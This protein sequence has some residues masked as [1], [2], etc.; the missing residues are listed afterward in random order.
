MSTIRSVRP[1]AFVLSL[2][3]AGASFAYQPDAAHEKAAKENAKVWK[4]EDRAID[5]KLAE[6]EKRFGKKP[7]IIYILADDIGWGELGSYLGGKLRGTP[8]PNLDKMARKGMQFLSHY[9]EPSCTPTRLAL[10]TGRHP[11]RTGVDIVLWPGQTQGLAAEEVTVAEMLS[12]AGYDTAMFGKWHVGDL[13]QHAP[14]NQGFDYAYY[15]L[16]NGAIYSWVNQK[17]FYEQQTIDGVG[18]FYDFPGTFEDYKNKYGIEILGAL[19]GKKGKGRKEIKSMGPE[20]MVEMEEDSINKIKSYIKDKADSDKPF[21]VYWAS[22]AQQMAS[23]PREYRFNE[24]QD[25]VNNQSAQL[26]Q[27]DD[28]IQQLLDTVKDA[29]IEE[30]TLIVW[31]SDNGPMYAFWP[32]AGYSWLRGAKGEVYEGGMRTPGFAVW[33]G[34]IEAGQQ[35]MDMISVTDLFVTATRIAGVENKIPSDRVVDGIDQLPLLLN[36]EGNGRRKHM[37]YYSGNDLKAIRMEDHKL[38][39][40]PGSKGGLPN[41]ELYNLIR[42]P[43]EKYG[44]MYNHLWAI[45]PFQRMVGAHMKLIKEKPHRKIK[46]GLF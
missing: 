21:F 26:A 12:K 28:Y 15:G 27:H 13:E 44:A 34:M 23:S 37:F 10:L 2:F 11:V 43:G 41:Y 36:G 46:S 17:N 38:V 19:E 29:G 42:D 16:Y 31:V 33:P 24:G 32:D 1:A 35:P 40:V 7:N 6:L 45:V 4:Q 3:V 8:T 9:S 20:S 25:Y 39:I 18:H 30:N 22:Y 14:E 5:K